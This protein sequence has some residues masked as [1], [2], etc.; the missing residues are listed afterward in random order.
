MM[1]GQ[2]CGFFTIGQFFNVSHFFPRL[3]LPIHLKIELSNFL[4][5]IFKLQME[6]LIIVSAIIQSKLC[7]YGV[8]VVHTYIGVEV[9]MVRK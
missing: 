3:Y 4:L 9:A 7:I 6:N 2:K 8:Y 5:C 1:T